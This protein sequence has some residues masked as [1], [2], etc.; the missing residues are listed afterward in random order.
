MAADSALRMRRRFTGTCLTEY[1]P[2]MD[3]RYRDMN[4]LMPPLIH[5][6]RLPTMAAQIIGS[7]GVRHAAIAR[8][9]TKLR[10]G[11]KA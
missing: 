1:F 10:F 8:E 11:N 2:P 5:E 3:G 4:S 6:E 9:E 7:V